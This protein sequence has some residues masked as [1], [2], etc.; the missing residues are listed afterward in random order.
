LNYELTKGKIVNT[1]QTQ[2]TNYV[3]SFITVNK[4]RYTRN[5]KIRKPIYF[6][7]LCEQ[8]IISLID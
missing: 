7:S 6:T 3:Q 1:T 5:Q 2:Q 4:I 8:T